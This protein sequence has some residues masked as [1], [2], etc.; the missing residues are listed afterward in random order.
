MSL[1]AHC[2]RLLSR[3]GRPA[4]WP[5]TASCRPAVT[6]L[7]DRTM[8][9]LLFVTNPG[10]TGVSG[11]GSLRGEVG[12]AHSGDTIVLPAS[13]VG[14]PVVLTRGEIPLT[15]SLT[16]QGASALTDVV[17][18][19]H[20]SRVFEVQAGAAVTLVNLTLTKG[21]GTT[22]SPGLTPDVADGLGGALYNAGS[23]TLQGCTLTGNAAAISLSGNS[24]ASATAEGGGLYNAGGATALV[25]YSNLTGNSAV[26]A[27]SACMGGSSNFPV[28]EGGGI[29]N[30]VG[31]TVTVIGSTLSGN[32]A[33]VSASASG[34]ELVFAQGGGI[35]NHG[36]VTVNSSTLSG[37]SASASLGSVVYEAVALGG[38][39]F[40][41]FKVGTASLSLCTLSGNS[42]T[43]STSSSGVVVFAVALGGGLYNEAEATATVSGSTLSG[44]SAA[45][46]ASGGGTTGSTRAAAGGGIYSDGTLLLDHSQ[47]TG[48]VTPAGADL[49]NDVDGTATLHRS[50]VGALSNN[51]GTVT[52]S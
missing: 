33:A 3:R 32:S 38:G 48:N 41:D 24:A 15:K 30:E 9:S 7:E 36:R 45:L 14:K 23:L 28:A 27:L 17:S 37:N 39:L 47:D 42:A 40:N 26:V 31:G 10:D 21:N 13:L 35:Y 46:S 5:R 16:I 8:P 18:G 43:V 1:L 6:A 2:L 19:N 22:G 52:V 49:F 29:Y 20:T 12:A 51:G 4:R 44:N 11:D 25:K 50:T 34:V